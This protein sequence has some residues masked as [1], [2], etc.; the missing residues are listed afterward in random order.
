MWLAGTQHADGG[1]GDAVVDPSN[2][3][4]TSLTSAVLHYCASEEYADQVRAGRRWVEKAG[5]FPILNNP[6]ATSMSGPGGPCTP[7]RGSTIGRAS[8]SCRPR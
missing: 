3:N 1:W 5:G 6:R 2:M 7:S 4:A 8:A